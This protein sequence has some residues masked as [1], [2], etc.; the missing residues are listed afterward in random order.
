MLN[1][2]SWLLVV[3]A[4][5]ANAAEHVFDFSEA[6]L[7]QPPP[8]FRSALSGSS[9]KP[10]D[11]KI[12]LDEVPP[13]LTPL[14]DRA[15]V[16][17]KRPVLGQV[18]QD[19]TDERFP[20]LVFDGESFSDF[21]LTTRFK[22][23]GGALEQ[24]AGIAF[25]MQ[26][27][28]NFYVIRAS[29][30]G[31]NVRFY[32]VVN[33]ERGSL[34]GPEV[35]VAKGAWHELKIQC[36]GNQIQCWFDGKDTIPPLT[37]NSFSAGKLAFWT[38]SDSLSY[39]ADTKVVYT[40]RVPMAQTIVKAMMKKYPRLFDLKI[41]TLDAGGRPRVSGCKNEKELASPG[42]KVEKDCLSASRIFYGKDKQAVSVVMP[43][44]DR[45]GE[46]IAAVRFVMETF[47]GQTEQNAL[48]RATPMLKEIQARVQSLEDLAQ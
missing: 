9:G 17:T 43:L 38:K 48:V 26:D 45:N 13:L 20:L 44:R 10:G 12:L 30:L 34:I 15:P 19:P 14:T 37:D 41:Y 6:A 3:F 46:T 24:M 11:W 42:G 29:A 18:S 5:S 7:N 25:R 36:R 23:A 28:K 31:N 47:T 35:P 21:T 22:I 39:F 1:R 16:V 40:P 8:G 32:K 4:L 27:E 33:G 2:L